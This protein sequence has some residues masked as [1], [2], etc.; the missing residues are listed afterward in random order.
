MNQLKSSNFIRIHRSTI[1]N[2]S[3][4]KE[5]ISSNYGELDVKM[6]DEKLFRISKTYKKEF[7]NKMG[8]KL[9]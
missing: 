7:Q 4:I 6:L 1:V 9:F 5:V 3:F 8:I 2:I